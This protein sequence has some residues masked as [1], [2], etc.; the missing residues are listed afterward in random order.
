MF[1]SDT[2]YNFGKCQSNLRVKETCL[3]ECWQMFEND[4]LVIKNASL[5]LNH[6]AF[7]C[8]STGYNKTMKTEERTQDSKSECPARC[9]SLLYTT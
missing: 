6:T 1:I 8:T 4:K 2:E 3:I 9:E 7:R 5:L